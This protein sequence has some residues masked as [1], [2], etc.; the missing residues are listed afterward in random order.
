MKWVG[1]L[2]ELMSMS[3][4]YKEVRADFDLIVYDTIDD[5]VEI[6]PMVVNLWEL[7]WPDEPQSVAMVRT[8]L[9]SNIGLDIPNPERN[10]SGSELWHHIVR[11]NLLVEVQAEANKVFGNTNFKRVIK[12][13]TI[14]RIGGPMPK[15]WRDENLWPS[16]LPDGV[17]PW[18]NDPDFYEY[19]GND[20]NPSPKRQRSGDLQ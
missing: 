18:D 1:G 9:E 17:R 20:P 19:P 11:D 3:E 16:D 15:E 2:M 4:Y 5:R 10:P 8:F 7:G 12:D 13:V 6:V 14:R